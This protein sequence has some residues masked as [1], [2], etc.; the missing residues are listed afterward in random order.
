[1]AASKGKGASAISARL[2][3]S[4]AIVGRENEP[5]YLLGDLWDCCNT[6]TTSNTKTA[7]V[8]DGTSQ[9]RLSPK[10][11]KSST[12]NHDARDDAKNDGDKQEEKSSAPVDA[13][14]SIGRG[15]FGRIMKRNNDTGFND[16]A[17]GT[18]ADDNGR[19]KQL[20]NNIVKDDDYD[21][22]P[23]GFFENSCNPF[24]HQQQQQQQR[25]SLTQQLVLHASLDVFEEKASSSQSSSGRNRS[26]GIGSVWGVRWRTPGTDSATSMYMG[27]LCRIDERWS[28][29]GEFETNYSFYN[30]FRCHNH[31][32]TH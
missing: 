4:V 9:H 22:D 14:S 24:Q 6:I 5:I 16:D 20:N 18:S 31:Y 23:F 3:T 28:V 15:L 2:L 19:Q 8:T 32:F 25:M 11:R 21:E 13:S 12:P 27:L 29:Y 30:N 17:S 10:S 26:S 1:M 7:T